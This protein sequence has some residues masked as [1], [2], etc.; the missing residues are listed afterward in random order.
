VKGLRWIALALGVLLSAGIIVWL[1]ARFHDGPLG[2]FPG[3]PMDGVIVTDAA[4][5]WSFATDLQTLALQTSDP[6]RS[7]S[8][9]LVV[10]EGALYVPSG[11]SVAER[12]PH[13]LARD[14]VAL[15]R[16]EERL[17]LRRAVR[18]SDPALLTVL[19]RKVANKYG[20]EA[21][22]DHESHWIFRME[23]FDPDG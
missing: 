18:V 17:Y 16:I 6:P 14:P 22:G 5:D 13:E 8:V 2:P 21:A 11:S 1:G 9:W 20:V 19:W 10:H 12:W 7:R 4:V 23:A 15:L 3:G